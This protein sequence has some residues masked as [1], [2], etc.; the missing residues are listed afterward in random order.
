[1]ATKRELILD[2][3]ARDKSGPAITGFGQ[4]LKNAGDEADKA[5]RKAKGFGQDSD[6]AARGA[7]NLGD[8][9]G[10]AQRRLAGLDRE[11]GESRTKLGGLAQA[12]ADTGDKAQRMDISKEI[13]RTETEIRKLDKSKGILAALIPD[14]NESASIGKKLAGQ[15]AGAAGTIGKSAGPIGMAL[16]ASIAVA[17]SPV[18]LGGISAALAGAVGGAGIAGGIAAAVSA[19]K[20]LQDAGKSL[21]KK[22]I[23]GIQ[24]EATQNFGG[25]IRAALGVL[26]D[27]A[28]RAVGKIGDIFENTS[29]S[30]VPFIRNIVQGGEA[31]LDA[32]AKIT[33]DGGAALDGLG[34]SVRVVAEGV[35]D[36]LTAV[37]DDG[38]GAASSLES[39]AGATADILRFTG[40]LIGA[41]N[42]LSDSPWMGLVP[43]IKDH[44]H[45]AAEAGDDLA[46]SQAAVTDGFNSAADAADR[47]KGAL[48]GL[49]EQLRAQTDP[50]FG[51]LD[52]Q[53]KLKEAQDRVKQSTKDHGKTSKETRTALRDLAKAALD[54]EGRAGELGET[55]NGQMTPAL[56]NTLRAA[57]LTDGQI[58]DLAGQFRNAK[59]AGDN[60][61]K[62]YKARAKVDGAAEAR[63]ELNR[64]AAAANAIPN[65]VTIAMR[66]TGVT[67]VSKAAHAVQKNSGRA[68]GGPVTNGVPYWVGEEGPE[69]IVPSTNGVVLD[70]V[71][72]AT[73]ARRGNTAAQTFGRP[74]LNA[75]KLHIEL[76]GQEEI[77]TMFRFFIRSA[78]LLQG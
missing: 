39:I 72:S 4:K 51:L 37:T 23:S 73:V 7:D 60:F 41:W 11:L 74:Q 29:S 63:R 6:R 40:E 33:D 61:A 8:E 54:L 75:Q 26:T 22:F 36:F 64:A 62:T 66:V 50:V 70:S 13:R 71:K 56:R 69:L 18:I 45:E 10:Q 16:G 49:S 46:G 27:A 5:G 25:P 43:L 3:L 20:S 77:R 14:G 35:A 52:A 21:G 15:L 30:V 67:N 76:L 47:E 78:N 19:D 9:A 1:M 38:E 48:E 65:V 57:G 53:D 42:S 58:S 24:G 12:F 2:L 32:F 68:R 55:F 28:D 31:I 59:G 44:Y 17:A 34:N